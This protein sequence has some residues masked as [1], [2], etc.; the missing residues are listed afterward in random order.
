MSCLVKLYFELSN[1]EHFHSFFVTFVKLR[2]LHTV[3]GWKTVPKKTVFDI[4]IKKSFS[5][6]SFINDVTQFEQYLTHSP[7][8]TL[9]ISKALVPSS[10]N[11]LTLPQ[12][13]DVIYGRPLGLNFP[14]ETWQKGKKKFVLQLYHCTCVQLLSLHTKIVRRCEFYANQTTLYFLFKKNGPTFSFS[15][16]FYCFSVGGNFLKYAP[17]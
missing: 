4:R 16:I 2:N 5:C 1:H 8:I 15:E 12:D 11:P 3:F 14:F 13:H 17:S 9:F 6:G 7:I 10:Q